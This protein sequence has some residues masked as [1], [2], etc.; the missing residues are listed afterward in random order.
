MSIVKWHG[1]Q[2][3]LTELGDYVEFILFPVHR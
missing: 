3:L 1:S 2:P